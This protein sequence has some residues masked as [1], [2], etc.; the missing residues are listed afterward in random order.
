MVIPEARKGNRPGSSFIERALRRPFLLAR[1][2]KTWSRRT[3]RTP[4]AVISALPSLVE[5][6]VIGKW[7]GD[8]E[9]GASVR[10]ERLLHGGLTDRILACAIDVHRDLGPGLMES[11]YRACLVDRLCR[12]GLTVRQEVPVSIDYKG[13]L[14]ESAYRA[15]LVVEDAVLLE[16]KSIDTL[17]P[18]HT[19]QVLTYLRFLNLRVGLLI[20]FNV[21]NMMKGIRRYIR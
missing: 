15:D 19:A 5:H 14:V 11:A 4:G 2:L 17:L 3:R 12:E 7:S 21:T 10:E 6:G 20:N 8:V 1:E 18:I 13:H 9:I 16:L